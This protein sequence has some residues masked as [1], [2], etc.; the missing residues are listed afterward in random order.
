M[1]QIERTLIVLKPDTLSRGLCGEILT[2]FEKAGL[3][4]IGAKMMKPSKDF[5]YHHYETIGKM[6]S[7]RGEKPFNDNLVYMQA[8]PVIAI[9]LE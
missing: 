4:I 3:K 6:I 9:V 7:R 5:F 2:R 8:T 1:S